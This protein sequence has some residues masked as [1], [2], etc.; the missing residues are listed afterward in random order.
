MLLFPFCTG[1]SRGT[2]IYVTCLLKD[3]KDSKLWNWDLN[4]G[5]LAPRLVP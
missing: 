4:P 5:G 2:G 1:E 3:T